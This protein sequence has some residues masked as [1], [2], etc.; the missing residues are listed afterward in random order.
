MSSSNENVEDDGVDGN[1]GGE[2]NKSNTSQQLRN[3]SQ[4]SNG[5]GKFKGT[6]SMSSNQLQVNFIIK[7]FHLKVFETNLK[8]IDKYLELF[9]YSPNL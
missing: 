3:G 8:L 6:K 9:V 2:L 1:P 4:M 7:N 5:A